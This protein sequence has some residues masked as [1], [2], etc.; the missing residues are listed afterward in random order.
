M[1][2]ADIALDKIRYSLTLI[3]FVQENV[4]HS[5]HTYNNHQITFLTLAVFMW[6]VLLSGQP[7]PLTKYTFPPGQLA[8]SALLM[9]FNMAR[10]VTFLSTSCEFL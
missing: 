10:R 5:A 2:I 4:K 1:A 7:F 9:S 6:R 3:V 8:T